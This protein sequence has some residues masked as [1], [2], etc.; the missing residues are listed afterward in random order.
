LVEQLFDD[1]W[2]AVGYLLYLLLGDGEVYFFKNFGVEGVPVL[3]FFVGGVGG[4]IV[5][6]GN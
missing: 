1:A 2:Y 5:V 3:Y 6:E 4:R